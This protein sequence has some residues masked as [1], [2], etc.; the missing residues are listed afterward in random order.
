MSPD[1]PTTCPCCAAKDAEIKQLTREL[2][3]IDLE[4]QAKDKLVIEFM[5]Q[6]RRAREAT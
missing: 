5:S 6:W 2:D 1:M 3:S 4:L